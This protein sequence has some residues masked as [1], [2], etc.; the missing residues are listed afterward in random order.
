[1]WRILKIKLLHSKISCLSK[2]YIL[3]LKS[4]FSKGKFHS[5]KNRSRIFKEN[6]SR[7]TKGIDQLSLNF[8]IKLKTKI[9]K[10]SICNVNIKNRSKLWDWKLIRSKHSTSKLLIRS[11]K[12]WKEK[13]KSRWRVFKS[14][15]KATLTSIINSISKCS[16]NSDR[17]VI[18]KRSDNLKK[19]YFYLT[20]KEISLRKKTQ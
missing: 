13:K 18:L 6:F 11:N 5:K 15:I 19:G 17:Q 16:E 7:Q 20:K 1:M 4:L 14:S 3:K 8:T 10:S 2:K 12:I 9:R